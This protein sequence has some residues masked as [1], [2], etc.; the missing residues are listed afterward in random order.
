MEKTDDTHEKKWNTTDAVRHTYP[1]Q[2]WK[3]YQTQ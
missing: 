1:K 3:E 2:E